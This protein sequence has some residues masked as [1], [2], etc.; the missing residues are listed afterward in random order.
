VWPVVPSRLDT[1]AVPWPRT[2]ATSDVRDPRCSAEVAADD[3]AARACPGRVVQVLDQRGDRLVEEG[4]AILH[5]LEDMVIDAWSS[6][7]ADPAASGPLSVAVTR[8]NSCLNKT[9]SQKASAVPRCSAV[10]VAHPRSSRSSRTRG[11]L[12]SVRTVPRL[13]WNESN[14]SLP[15]ESFRTTAHL[16]KP[17]AQ[18]HTDRPGG[19]SAGGP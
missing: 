2:T 14:A 16:V 6:Q 10:A 18:V 17:L 15:R 3:Q 4:C 7:L 12:R 13:A 5:R 1:P 19:R 9:A 8:S 11:G